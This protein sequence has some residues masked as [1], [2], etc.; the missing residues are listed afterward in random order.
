V[1]NNVKVIGPIDIPYRFTTTPAAKLLLFCKS[2]ITLQRL[3]HIPGPYRELYADSP[4]MGLSDRL[5]NPPSH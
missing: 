4:S 1:L 2:G 5:F 3:M